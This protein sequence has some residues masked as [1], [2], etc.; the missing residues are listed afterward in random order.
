MV[1]IARGMVEIHS[2]KPCQDNYL[3][4]KKER[5]KE[6]G[7]IHISQGNEFHFKQ[8]EPESQRISTPTNNLVLIEVEK[9]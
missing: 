2:N 3:Q 7:R 1:R 8:S 9:R 5:C 4:K 6:K